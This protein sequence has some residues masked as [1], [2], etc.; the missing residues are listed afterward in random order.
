MYG[1]LFTVDFNDVTVSA[2]QDLLTIKAGATQ[3]II[4]HSVQFSQK[5][6]TSWEGKN[7]RFRYTPNTVTLGTG[8]TTPT[9]RGTDAGGMAAASSATIH[10]NDVTTFATS[11]GT[12]TD[13]W[14]EEWAF[15]NGFLWVPADPR[16]RILIKPTD[17]LAIHL[18][19]APSSAMVASGSVQYEEIG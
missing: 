11:S 5:T 19:T 14:S 10:A 4:V 16:G 18:D 13:L 12:I 9:P 7:I 17:A 3:P 8:G 6:L 15:L 2:I 1:R